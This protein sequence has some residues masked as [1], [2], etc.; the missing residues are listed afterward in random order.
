MLQR[1]ASLT[2]EF[3]A[4]PKTDTIYDIFMLS[5]LMTHAVELII[6]G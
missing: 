6:A 2:A 3:S 5:C 1:A 4:V